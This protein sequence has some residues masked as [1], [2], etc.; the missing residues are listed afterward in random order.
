MDNDEAKRRAFEHID[1]TREDLVSFLREYVQ[2]RS[3][4]PEREIAD[5]ERGDTTLC[6]N[7]LLDWL[8]AS[9]DFA[10]VESWNVS[11]GEI[12]VAAQ[13]QATSPDSYRSVLFNGH[14]D[15]VPVTAAEYA[16][17]RGGDPW[18]GHVEDGALY[19]RGACDMKG[20]NA[21][22]IWAARSLAKVG[23][24]PRGRITLTFTIGEESGAADLGPNSVKRQGYPSDVVV[25][26]EP[27][28]LQVC[29][30]AVGWFFFRV[31]ATGKASHA[32]SRGA[33][34]H[35]SKAQGPAGVNAIEALLP[36]VADLR[37]LER[38][39]GVYEKHPLMEPGTA[40][41][42]IVSICG[43]AEQATTPQSCHAIWTAIVSPNR[44][45]SE[46]RDQ[47]ARVLDATGAKNSWLM[48]TPLELTA[49]YLQGYFE[50]VN[51]P[52]D[53]PACTTML[54]AIRSVS[55]SPSEF[56]CMPTPSDANFFAENSQPVLV[57]GPGNLL[58][59]G[60]HG[61]NEHIE[62]DSLM[63]AAKAYASFMIDFSSAPR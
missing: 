19:G 1:N 59:N 15:V 23:F 41:I 56:R 27:T 13:L 14:S 62:I 46:I 5:V 33:S 26:A 4:N 52:V 11:S 35:P 2:R 31:D 44:R 40:A 34:I 8:R 50:P 49:P 25:V 36:A 45:C 9:K 10:K 12:N 17:W 22:V 3:I 61:L 60:V 28:G 58:G 42:N 39:W 24:A 38:D 57:F 54:R 53:H 51:T 16:S 55:D 43:G 30:A 7:W 20:G 32:A 6:Q 37:E 18:S 63:T 21:A 29:P 48:Q 47:I